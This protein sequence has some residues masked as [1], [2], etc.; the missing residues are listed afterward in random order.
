MDFGRQQ[1]DKDI[2]Q[3]SEGQKKKLL[4]TRSLCEQAH[5]YVWDEPLNYID[6]FSRVQLEE[7]IQAFRPTM[8]LVEHDRAFLDRVCTNRR[9]TRVTRPVL[10]RLSSV[11]GATSAKAWDIE[12]RPRAGVPRL[13]MPTAS[14]PPLCAAS[15][16]RLRV[17][18]TPRIRTA[19]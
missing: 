2:A 15:N 14:M 8:L 1:F 16:A 4:L 6:V 19:E 5:L 17:P 12:D 18:Q 9:A 11:S 10:S 13:P 7:L 3:Y